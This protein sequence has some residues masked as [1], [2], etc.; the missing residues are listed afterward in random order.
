MEALQQLAG[1]DVPEGAGG[2]TRPRQDLV[3]GSGEEAAGH[4]AGVRPHRPLLCRHVLLQGQGVN[5][6]LV[7]EAATGDNLEI[8]MSLSVVLVRWVN[9]EPSS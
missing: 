5:G 9:S 6:H 4:V 1:F 3:V 7:V 2:V 8:R